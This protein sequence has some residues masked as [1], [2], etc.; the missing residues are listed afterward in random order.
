MAAMPVARDLIGFFKAAAGLFFNLISC[1]TVCKLS[2]KINWLLSNVPKI[3]EA[4]L[5]E[6][7]FTF[8]NNNAGPLASKIRR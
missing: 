3:L 1:S 2:L 6:V 4:A 5:K 7:P 8:S